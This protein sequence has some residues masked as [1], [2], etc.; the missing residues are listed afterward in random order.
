MLVLVFHPF[1]G[2]HASANT[3]P[4]VSSQLAAGPPMQATGPPMQ[5]TGPPMQATGP[6]MRMQGWESVC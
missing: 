6:P 5:D 4:T 1:W 3:K 2:L